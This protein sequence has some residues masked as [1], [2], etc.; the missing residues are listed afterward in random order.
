[1]ICVV[2]T[3]EPGSLFGQLE[4][5]PM[6]E[7]NDVTSEIT[8]LYTEIE[9]PELLYA[10]VEKH[11][12]H[13]GIH[14]WAEDDNYYRVRIIKEMVHE[15]D[16]FFIDYGNVLCVPRCNILAPVESLTR[17]QHTPFGIRCRFLDQV[18]LS[19]DQWYEAIVEKSL[20]VK[21]GKCEDGIYS[22]SLTEDAINM[23]V[24]KIFKPKVQ[25]QTSSL[26]EG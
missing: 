20:R 7:L 3:E 5:F 11:L 25:L 26:S 18:T 13:I 15:V 14:K 22:V 9:K 19:K 21:I 6:E 8:K 12:G 4:K 1:M 2:F 24:S 23:D 17:F 16:I 10:D